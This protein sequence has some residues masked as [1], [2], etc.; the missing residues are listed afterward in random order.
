M[1]ETTTKV[2]ETSPEPIDLFGGVRDIWN[3]VRRRRFWIVG[4]IL[5]GIAAAVGVHFLLPVVSEAQAKI[6]VIKKDANLPAEGAANGTEFEGSVVEDILSTH[7]EILSSPRIIARALTSASLMELPSV[8][9]ELKDDQ[10]S[11][12]YVKEQ[13]EITR[14]GEGQAKAAHVLNVTFSHPNPEDAARILDAVIESYRQFV[15]ETFQNV[16]TEAV[17][18]ISQASKDL[19]EDLEQK[20]LVLLEHREQAPLLWNDAESQ[21]I[22][23][24]RID[25]YTSELATLNVRKARLEARLKVTS[26]A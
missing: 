21:N 20:H 1:Y 6:L 3:F 15:D 18:L 11:V 23:Q 8:L 26:L 24:T 2:N 7:M 16:G 17:S 10:D 12:D 25:Q 13:L 19:T 9:A 5:L 4:G 22:H 14:G